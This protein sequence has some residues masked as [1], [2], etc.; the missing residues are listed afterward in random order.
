MADNFLSR[1][2]EKAAVLHPVH[3]P[4]QTVFDAGCDQ[5]GSGDR[6]DC[7]GDRGADFHWQPGR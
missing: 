4:A 7:G 1:L 6:G 2:R 3:L 5:S